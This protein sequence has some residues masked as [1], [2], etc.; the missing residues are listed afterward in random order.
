[1]I[2]CLH[3]S[4][5]MAS[6]PAWRPSSRLRGGSAELDWED[7]CWKTLYLATELMLHSWR[8]QNWQWENVC[9][10]ITPNIWPPN[11]PDS[12][13]LNYY[14]WGVVEW[15][16]HKIPSNTKK[17]LKVMITAAFTNWNKEATRKACRRF[18]SHLE[19]WLKPMSI[20]L[21]EFNTYHFKI[22]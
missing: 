16:T 20:S 18:W 10:H 21:N 7:G 15:E 6:D 14:I 2:L 9:Y 1:M 19:S 11:S 5:H 3:S 17:K 13:P 4:F 8:T 12:N 22:F